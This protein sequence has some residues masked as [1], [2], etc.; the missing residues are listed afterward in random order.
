MK[1][2]AILFLLLAGLT[3]LARVSPLRAHWAQSS[4]DGGDSGDDGDD[5]DDAD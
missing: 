5:S 3:A 2:I 4:D 1:R